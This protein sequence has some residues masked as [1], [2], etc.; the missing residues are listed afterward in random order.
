[1]FCVTGQQSS[2]TKIFLGLFPILLALALVTSVL[3]INVIGSFR[4]LLVGKYRREDWTRRGHTQ[5]V[6]SCGGARRM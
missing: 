5:T 4:D 6:G 3:N 1:M 2:G